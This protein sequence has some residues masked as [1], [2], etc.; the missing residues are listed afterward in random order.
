MK[1]RRYNDKRPLSTLHP[2]PRHWTR[3]P[4]SN[5]WKAKVAYESEEEAEEYL[6]TNIRLKEIGYSAYLCPVCNKWHVGHLH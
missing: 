5:S 4:K 6:Q 1:R 2:D 3:K